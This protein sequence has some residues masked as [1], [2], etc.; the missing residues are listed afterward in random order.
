[1]LDWV[2]ALCVGRILVLALT[3]LLIS[4][5]PDCR[6]PKADPERNH[7]SA[8][9]HA[10]LPQATHPEGKTPTCLPAPEPL[11]LTPSWLLICGG[12]NMEIVHPPRQRN[13]F[14][15]LLETSAFGLK[16]VALKQI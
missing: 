4:P 7:F 16:S 2:L 9:V 13:L 5:T 10:S 1:M 14:I 15:P 8:C 3:F 6:W 11:P 12:G